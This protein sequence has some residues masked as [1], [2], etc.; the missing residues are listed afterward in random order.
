MTVFLGTL[1]FHEG[2]QGSFMFDGE[3]A[4]PLHTMQ[5]NRASSLGEEEVSWL[6]SSCSGNLGYILQLQRGW[7]FKTR[8]SS[9]TSGLLLSCERHLGILPEA[10]LHNKDVS[11]CEVGD[12]GSRSSCHRDIGI[13]INFQEKSGII[14]F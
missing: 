9:A 5:G 10:W 13:P 14:S 7:P 1:E 8:V 6:F 11:R 4:I 2:S 12:P 3:N